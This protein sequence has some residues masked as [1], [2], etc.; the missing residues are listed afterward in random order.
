MNMVRMA[1]VERNKA[2][3][4]SAVYQAE[5]FEDALRRTLPKMPTDC[6]ELMAYFR[7]VEQ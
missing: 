7:R 1:E 3:E 4:N 6:V 2:R 5:L